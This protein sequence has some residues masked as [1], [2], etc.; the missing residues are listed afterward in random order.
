MSLLKEDLPVFVRKAEENFKKYGYLAA[1]FIAVL[2]EK[3][4]IFSLV[5]KLPSDKEA[6]AQQIQQWIAENRLSEYIMIFEAWA[7]FAD[8][9]ESNKW[10]EIH[11]TLENW[12]N[13]N[14]ILCVQYCS[15]T[16]EISY[17]TTIN[18][19]KIPV[20]LEKWD[21]A[22]QDVKF[23]SREFSS[24]FQGLFLKGKSGQN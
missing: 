16:E 24:R 20:T 12:P 21:I 19:G 3:P 18:R 22:H 8:Q 7:A 4:Q 10:L 2:D 17:T 15:P 14:E 1:T 6:F 23:N 11:G 9:A 5:L 13:R